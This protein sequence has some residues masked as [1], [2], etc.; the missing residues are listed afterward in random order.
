MRRKTRTDAAG[1]VASAGFLS[2]IVLTALLPILTIASI[3]YVKS[4]PRRSSCSLARRAH[5]ELVNAVRV[6]SNGLETFAYRK[7]HIALQSSLIESYM[8]LR[9]KTSAFLAH[10]ET[11]ADL[12]MREHRGLHRMYSRMWL[13]GQFQLSSYQ[14]DGLEFALCARYPIDG[15]LLYIF[16][17][18][19]ARNKVALELDGAAGAGVFRG[20]A[21][22]ALLNGWNALLV[23]R[24]W[25]AFSAMQQYFD[26][27]VGDGVS[28]WRKKH[29]PDSSVVVAEES[30]L[31]SNVNDAI[32][33]NGVSGG[34]DAMF[35]MLDG[36]DLHAWEQLSIVSPRV[37][38]LFYQD[39]W[40]HSTKATRFWN[41][42]DDDSNRGE[43]D[44]VDQGR[45]R[46]FVGASIAA[47][48]DTANNLGFRLVWCLRA[49]PIAI[50]LRSN[51]D[52]NHL[53][54]PPVSLK[55]CLS[56]R[57]SAKW[58]LDMEAQWD[59]AQRFSW[60]KDPN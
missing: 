49:A 14:R 20:S 37:V 39:F 23:Y 57:R 15:V 36:P 28:G 17:V 32:A 34:V 9:R 16:G 21:G 11:C 12:A 7:Q 22:L 55:S 56:R 8:N 10:F 3:W 58:L 45:R 53:L 47:T 24:K 4:S 29:F 5:D 31:F 40:G 18:L 43:T 1:P 33:R 41:F 54:L 27:S 60:N 42:T 59:R 2:L 48:V 38:L 19:G 25:S 26:S 35:L 52:P 44:G 13:R 51:E 6:S 50:F 30:A 46:L